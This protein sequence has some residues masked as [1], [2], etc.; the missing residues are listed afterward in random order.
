[1]NLTTA[2]KATLA[3]HINANTNVL[4]IPPGLG[5]G[6]FVVNAEVAGRDP[7]LQGLIAAWYNDIALSGD[8]QPFGNLMLWNPATTIQQLNT[9]VDWTLNVFGATAA[10]QTNGWLKWQSMCWNNY[11][12]MTDVQ[13]RAG[14]LQIWTG[15]ITPAT[16]NTTITGIGRSTG[17]LCGKLA[18]RRIDLVVAGN[19]V[20]NVTNA[21]AGAR[22]CP[23]GAGGVPLLSYFQG[24][25]FV[26]AQTLSQ[27]DV[28]QALFPNG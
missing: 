2:Q 11:L 9:A 12:D 6:T 1:M 24:T 26:P 4:T 25:Q 8:S 15:T 27:I 18:G 10:D 13:V 20:G 19:A 14:V 22:V 28:D 3:A 23:A 5:T 7:T 21:W 17:T 16:S